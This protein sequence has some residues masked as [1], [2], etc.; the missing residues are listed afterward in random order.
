MSKRNNENFSDWRFL[1]SPWAANVSSNFQNCL[2]STHSKPSISSSLK[3]VLQFDNIAKL[4]LSTFSHSVTVTSSLPPSLPF[5]T[6]EIFARW[7]HFLYKKYSLYFLS[8]LKRHFVWLVYFI[9]DC[10]PHRV[11]YVISVPCPCPST[12][13]NQT[14]VL[15][16]SKWLASQMLAWDS[17][18]FST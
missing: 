15:Q 11:F 3:P 6:K 9:E 7:K 18:G 8:A 12:P 1:F 2:V 14:Y 5:F 17:A 4:F 10:N 13:G 16:I